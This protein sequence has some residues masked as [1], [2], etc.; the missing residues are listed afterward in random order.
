M[1]LS[2]T[3][4]LDKVKQKPEPVR[5]SLALVLAGVLTIAIIS[6]WLVIFKINDDKVATAPANVI[7]SPGP[8]ERFSAI[9]SGE[10]ANVG[11][12]VSELKDLIVRNPLFN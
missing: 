9:M 4:Y 5:H 6:A 3:S 11:K 12:G 8:I 10:L 2:Q 1:P 7:E